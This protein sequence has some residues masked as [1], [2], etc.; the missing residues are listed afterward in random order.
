[1]QPTRRTWTAVAVAGTLALFAAIVGS[2]VPAIGSALIFGWVVALQSVTVDRFRTTVDGTTISVEPAVTAAQVDTDI[3]VLLIVER[4]PNAAETTLKVSLSM[5]AVATPVPESERQ[6][7]LEVGE[8]RAKTS[9]LLSASI[10]SR[11]TFS[12]PTWELADSHFVF[13]ESFDR[14][15]T[16]TV[17]FEATRIRDLHV[18]RGGVEL[19]AFGQHPTDKTGDGLTPAELRQYIGDESADR[20]DWKATAR[21]SEAYVREFQTESDRELTLII[22]HRSE[23][24][25]GS[26]ETSMLAY[27]REVALM[28][29]GTAETEGDPVGLITVGDDG[30]TKTISATRQPSGYAQ[31]KE[32]LLSLEPTPAGPPSSSVDLKHPK[33]TRR[34]AKQLAGDESIFATKIRQFTATAPSYIHRIEK[35]SLYGAVDY[36]QATTTATHLTAIL[37]TDAN[38]PWLRETVQAAAHGGN[39]VRVFITPQVLFS[40][41]ELSN[42]ERAYNR[43]YDFEQFRAELEQ[44]G[45]V[46][47]YEVGPGDR[48]ERLLSARR[49]DAVGRQSASGGVQ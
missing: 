35:D 8:T 36:L 46:S 47:A 18:G 21:L 48:L 49:A 25:R 13:S 30:L 27:I 2:I 19:S 45:P 34:L 15:P 38:R 41:S 20:I 10:A 40:A 14:G 9:F 44:F 39:S 37:T 12:E 31:I 24:E 5:P 1:M 17:T 43:Y 42:I 22:D 23:M 29:V 3:P 11:I 4:P 6:V 26:T 16:P 33:T 28:L 32:R 7:T